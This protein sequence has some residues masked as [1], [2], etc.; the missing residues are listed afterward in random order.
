MKIN[1]RI[2]LITFSV[3]VLIS[4]TSTLIYYSLTNT[5]IQKQNA[6]VVLN[7]TNDFVFFL[8]NSLDKTDESFQLLI[9]D[10]GE[11]KN[12]DL[13]NS[14][15]DFL[16]TL[17][18]DNFINKLNF[19]SKGK[20][21]L[22][23]HG[24]TIESFLDSNP[25]VVIKFR[26]FDLG[27][28]VFYGKVIDQ[29]FLDEAA[30]KI[31]CEVS[32]I[33]NNLP[34]L[35]SNT[36]QN[37]TFQIN[38]ID[39]FNELKFK[40]NF[41]IVFENREE[42]D[43][44]VVKY[45]PKDIL[46]ANSKLEFLVFKTFSESSEFISTMRELILVIILTGIVLTFIFAL[47]F[48]S[49]I[50][51]QL[52]LLTDAAEKTAA[53]SLDHRVD[54][55][56]K[57]E[58]GNLGHSFNTMLSELQRNREKEQEYAEF[59]ALI[60]RNPTL[61]EF[62]DAV[63]NKILEVTGLKFAGIYTVENNN[64]RLITSKGL[65][66]NVDKRTSDKNIFNS[67]IQKKETIELQFEENL[68][69]I[70]TSVVD[71]KIKYLLVIPI[72]YN[73]ET[74]GVIEFAS[75]HTP[76]VKPLEYLNLIKEQLAIGLVNARSYEK[77]ENLVEELSTLN[78]EYQKQNE[79]IM[80]QNK[81]LVELHK[82]LEEKAAELEEERKRAVE[83]THVKSQFLASM[84]HELKTPLNSIIGLTELTESDDST[85]PKNRDRLKIVLR[86]S[87]KLL[88]MIN[89]ILEFSKIESGKFEISKSN[90][91]LGN[92]LNE[93]YLSAK[94]LVTEKNLSFD[95]KLEN[96]ND[97]LVNTDKTKLEHI[98]LN[99]LSNAVKFTEK[100]SIHI[101]VYASDKKN[102]KVKVI[103]TG[104]GIPAD[105]IDSIFEEFKQLDAG[106]SRRYSG[107]GL[108]LAI[109]KK[110]SALLNGNLSVESTL[111]KGSTFTLNLPDV[112]V[113]EIES[114]V[115][116][117]FGIR[118]NTISST[119]GKPKRKKIELDVNHP[120]SLE[121]ESSSENTYQIL[122]VDDDNDA[123][124][125]VGEVLQNFGY[126]IS[127]ASNGLECLQSLEKSKPDLVLLDIMM[128]V[129]DGFEAVSRIRKNPDFTDL[130]VVALT[131]HAM[132]DDKHVIE[133]SGFDDL[134]TKPVNR[135]NLQLKI[136]QILETNERDA[137]K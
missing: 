131:A 106:N 120:V 65:D 31:R 96:P 32:L 110:Y 11:L 42:I 44:A 66:R 79:Q 58:L 15:I 102:L 6:S 87:K 130:K 50:R 24:K 98:I 69:I 60:N 4:V 75:E 126:E 119:L 100:G 33:V 116:L 92:L 21:L 132:L 36:S 91:L 117:R 39:A 48:T 81:E 88:S 121:E 135:L 18:E 118:Q 105:E 85:L 20:Y 43:I 80:G 26:V 35:I 68:P 41:D 112:I 45:Q 8:E 56:S 17:N 103:D 123:L 136:K 67:V 51:R 82:K 99:L 63:L 70:H 78:S 52:T 93:I 76:Q 57:D 37:S 109:C 40:N 5:I 107:A 16:F 61:L 38:L 73:K 9:K 124:F 90:F 25:N 95:I 74:I 134:I 62:G 108:G 29:K 30:K 115:N 125:T 3:V 49:K 114:N 14:A 72:V 86:N 19:Y 23:F 10:P 34:Y 133:N 12:I 84:S 122:V 55:I 46:S 89:N 59:I 83:L 27:E 13:E 53:G 77:L 128:P 127:F 113:D 54:V 71:I 22:N 104:I 7:S 28:T 64:L 2:L 47:L 1:V 111:G 129:M 137:D 101:V 94:P 97:L